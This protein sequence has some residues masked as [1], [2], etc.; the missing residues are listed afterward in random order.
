MT[1]ILEGIV[2]STAYGL[3]RVGSDVDRLGVFVAPTLQVAG[4]DWSA[5]RETRVQR[6]PSDR[7]LHEVGKFCR[8]ALGCN[9]T[10]LEMLWLPDDLYEVRAQEGEALVAARSA[11]LSE[12]R[13][14]D[15]Y[16]G[17]AV[18]Q[19]RR[20]RD[21]GDGSFSSDT[22][23][24]TVKHARHMLRLLRQGR[25]LLETG[26]LPIRV[27]QPESYFALDDMT[28]DQM[29][30]VY[31][32]ELAGFDGA[33]TG[34]PGVPDR[35]RVICVLDLIRRRHVDAPRDTM[36]GPVNDAP[37]P[38]TPPQPGIDGSSPLGAGS[39]TP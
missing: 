26:V 5:H 36:T 17:Y 2:G 20:L 30:A 4:L 39:L 8:L 14:R 21:R 29:L 16:G 31:E 9:P 3:G 28:V 1:V 33:S 27:M 25:S 22:R 35:K 19:M 11:F 32:R 37:R 12:K 6:V 13:V 18:Q 38:G 23:N 24:R 15:A 34:L 10:V 7:T